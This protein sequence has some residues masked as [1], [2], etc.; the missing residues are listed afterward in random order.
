MKELSPEL[1]A[2]LRAV[3][4]T[5]RVRALLLLRG[6][7]GCSLREAVDALERLAPTAHEERFSPHAELLAFGPFSPAIAEH[8]DYPAGYYAGVEPGTPLSVLVGEVHGPEWVA[9][10]AEMLGLDPTDMNQWCVP[11]EHV[12]ARALAA[13]EICEAG[14]VEALRSAG[15]SFHFMIDPR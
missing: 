13:A 2:E 4:Q 7:A 12:D 8:L 15:F 6:A 11:P 10:L 14:D 9:R 3:A 5:S 1:R